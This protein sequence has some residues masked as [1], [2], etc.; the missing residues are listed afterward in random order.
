[1]INR[2]LE[3][4]EKT[5]SQCQHFCYSRMNTTLEPDTQRTQPLWHSIKAA[6]RS[7]NSKEA[8]IFCPHL[9]A[10]CL[11]AQSSF[12]QLPISELILKL[13]FYNSLSAYDRVS[14]LMWS[15]MSVYNQNICTPQTWF[16]LSNQYNKSTRINQV[17]SKLNNGV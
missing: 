1:M 6:A 13:C 17:S 16:F 11:A 7:D 3:L 9:S 4:F 12:R 2:T 15:V 10:P 8:K 5:R 14:K